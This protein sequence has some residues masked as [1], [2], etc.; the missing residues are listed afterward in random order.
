MNGYYEGF[1][2]LFGRYGDNNTCSLNGVESAEGK[3]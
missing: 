2:I 3:M 1:K